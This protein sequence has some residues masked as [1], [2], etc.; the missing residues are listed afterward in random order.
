MSYVVKI[1]LN[2]RPFFFSDCFRFVRLTHSVR[3]FD[4]S[5]GIFSLYQ[6]VS[7]QKYM[8]KPR[9]K[10]PDDVFRLVCPANFFFFGLC[11]ITK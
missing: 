9:H 11:K 4:L 8:T 1:D 5:D 3:F 6:C 7:V 10:T 2:L